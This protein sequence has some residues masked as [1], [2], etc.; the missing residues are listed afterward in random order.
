MACRLHGSIGPMATNQQAFDPKKSRQVPCW[1]TNSRTSSFAPWRTTPISVPLWM[2]AA[3]WAMR[4]WRISR[5]R[6]T[7]ELTFFRPE[8]FGSGNGH[9]QKKERTSLFF[10]MFYIV[11]SY[12][13]IGIYIYI[14]VRLMRWE[15]KMIYI[16]IYNIV[17]LCMVYVYA[18]FSPKK[19]DP[20]SPHSLLVVLGQPPATLGVGL[21]DPQGES[22]KRRGQVWRSWR[23]ILRHWVW[24]SA[25]QNFL[26]PMRGL[27]NYMKWW[28]K[29]TPLRIL[30]WCFMMLHDASWCFMML[31]DASWCFMMLHDASWLPFCGMVHDWVYYM[32]FTSEWGGI[33]DSPWLHP[34]C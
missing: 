10:Q 14:F 30:R 32:N 24:I 31:H 16:Y 3:N 27:W 19:A 6:Q 17:G 9:H 12:Q 25:A 28:N 5:L 20:F 2:A 26:D 7:A 34:D 11:I 23:W 21:W 4:Q 18:S 29:W 13:F 22:G 15:W 8:I 33:Q 1:T